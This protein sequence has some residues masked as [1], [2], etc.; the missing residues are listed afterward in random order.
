MSRPA[1]TRR[2]YC[3]ACQETRPLS[4]FSKNQRTNKARPRCKSCIRSES[5]GLLRCGTCHQHKRFSAYSH[6]QL[7]KRAHT[8]TRLRCKACMFFAVHAQH[9]HK[10]SI[11]SV[12][13]LF[14]PLHV[15]CMDMHSN[16]DWTAV[17][18]IV[19]S[20]DGDIIIY[21][22][23]LS[24]MHTQPVR[25]QLLKS[26]R[27]H[28][29]CVE[30]LHVHRT[31][32]LFVSAGCDNNVKIWSL[33]HTH[34]ELNAPPLLITSIP[35]PESV[36]SVKYSHSDLLLTGCRDG[37]LRVYGVEP[38]CSLLWSC[39]LSG[40]VCTVAWSPS[41]HRIAACF[42]DDMSCGRDDYVV[43]T[44]N[45]TDIVKLNV[46][47]VN[48]EPRITYKLRGNY[49]VVFASDD[50][51][52]CTTNQSRNLL[53]YNICTS[54]VTTYQ[55]PRPSLIATVTA[56]SSELVCVTTS[57][58]MLRMYRVHGS[59]LQLFA[60]FPYG[61]SGDLV[62]SLCPYGDAGY[63]LASWTVKR[64]SWNTDVHIS[65]TSKLSYWFPA[66]T[67][68]MFKSTILPFCKDVYKIILK[69]AR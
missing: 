25:F 45:W 48:A 66:L 63:M 21:H 18:L 57:D 12:Q 42:G 14:I 24:Y 65:V 20:H 34:T 27:A 15:T 30:S 22:T 64:T 47:S 5:S 8:H 11:K 7:H 52:L 36:P 1:R 4:S 6:T 67:K 33:S 32:P 69:Y 59:E 17:T 50:L 37:V 28:T 23:P 58:D 10:R 51:L 31:K 39:K 13:K 38:L 29:D 26:F 68:M 41:N 62:S 16:A 44:W 3:H 46:K 61:W 9:T 60:T 54:K 43:R 53:L 2:L 40:R 19:G 56:L 35:H 49:V 55:Y